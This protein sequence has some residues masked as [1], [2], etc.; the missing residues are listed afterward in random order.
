[1]KNRKLLLCYQRVNGVF[2]CSKEV[3]T[4]KGKRS[5]R[6]NSGSALNKRS[7]SFCLSIS[8]FH[9][10]FRSTHKEAVSNNFC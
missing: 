1:M 5:R 2:L 10:N 8:S 4:I 6:T 9:W 7:K 3:Q